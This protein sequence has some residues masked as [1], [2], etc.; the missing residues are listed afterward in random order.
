[1]TPLT[2]NGVKDT[3]RLK[4]KP[5]TATGKAKDKVKAAVRKRPTAAH[6]V[7]DWEADLKHRIESYPIRRSAK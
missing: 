4:K 1:M 6:E 5:T 3:A 7:A 2:A